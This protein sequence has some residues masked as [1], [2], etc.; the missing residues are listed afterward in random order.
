M[1]GLFILSLDT[2]IAWGTEGKRALAHHAPS[3]DNY[4]LLFRRLIE[5]LDRYEIPATF[6]V[7]GHLFLK[8]GDR[9]SIVSGEGGD[10]RLDWYHAPDIIQA[11]QSART[12]HE[13]G[14]HT[15]SH[16]YTSR[17]S[18]G[19]WNVELAACASIHREHRLPL[20]SLVFPRNE[21]DYLNTLPRYGIIAYRGRQEGWYDRYPKPLNR[22]AHL[23]DR[24]L[25]LQPPTYD[26][27]CLQVNDKLVNLPAS[28][29]LI[30]YDGVRQYI[31]T[32]TRVAQA[33]KGLD[34]AVERGEL[35]HLW[36]HPFNL[37]S[38]EKMFDALEQILSE[39]A[40]RREAGQLRVMTMEGAAKWVLNG[41]R[42]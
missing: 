24:A 32:A 27:T 9:R 1:A 22:A 34:R 21:V 38:S 11:I 35:F 7:V 13:I 37:G 8:P 10:T 18:V 25:G 23:A 14:C 3:F 20:R 15:F 41:M 5:T 40:R 26:L 19:R 2:E 12:P 42:E 17:V 30:Q 6:A 36:F 31:P 4:R 29:F 28:Q 33:R 39:V 16:A